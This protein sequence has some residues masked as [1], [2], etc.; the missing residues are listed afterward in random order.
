MTQ[1]RATIKENP[2]ILELGGTLDATHTA[3]CH[4][5]RRRPRDCPARPSPGV[6]TSHLLFHLGQ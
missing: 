6:L 3:P 4:R 1:K 2:R 5:E